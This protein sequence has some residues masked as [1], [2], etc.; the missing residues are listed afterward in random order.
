MVIPG[1]V[2][3]AAVILPKQENAAT[4]LGVIG[5]LRLVQVVLPQAKRET[6]LV[7]LQMPQAVHK[8]GP[9]L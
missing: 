5:A 1:R 6:A 9:A 8:H 7:M 3:A 2:Q 4:V